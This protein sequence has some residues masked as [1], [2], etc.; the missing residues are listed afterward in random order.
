MDDDDDDTDT[1]SNYDMKIYVFIPIN[2][3]F[4]K[5]SKCPDLTG[6]NLNFVE[7][8]AGFERSKEYLFYLICRLSMGNNFYRDF[9]NMY[10]PLEPLRQL[11]LS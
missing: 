4:Q 9:K 6:Q 8:V 10:S 11:S 5:H 7:I 1:D 3:Q 2:R